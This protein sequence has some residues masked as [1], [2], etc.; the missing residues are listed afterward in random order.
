VI[1]VVFP[2]HLRTL[3]KVGKEVEVQFDGP[4]TQRAILDAL[5]ATYPVLQGTIRDRVTLRRRPLLRFFACEQDLSDEPPDA[6]LPDAVAM[7]S[8]PFMIVGAM[9]GG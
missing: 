9:A 8:E 1:R 4:V 5:E 3:A 2:P 6:P 7:G